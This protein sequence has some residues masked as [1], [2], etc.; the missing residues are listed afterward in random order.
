MTISKTKAGEILRNG[1]IQFENQQYEKSYKSFTMYKNIGLTLTDDLIEKLLIAKLKI[2][3]P[4]Y[5]IS[6]KNS[7]FEKIMKENSESTIKK[8]KA[9]SILNFGKHKYKSVS[10]TAK[11]HTLDLF[12]IINTMDF[13]SV[14]HVVMLDDR[15]SNCQGYLKALEN[16]LAKFAVKKTVSANEDAYRI[17]ERLEMEEEIAMLRRDAA[18]EAAM[19]KATFNV[20]NGW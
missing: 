13:F 14:E 11:E 5:D 4:E 20:M 1:L 2:N 10:Q 15:L 17:R 9:K 12:E 3:L 19:N 18:R 8:Y 16:N 6:G 7:L